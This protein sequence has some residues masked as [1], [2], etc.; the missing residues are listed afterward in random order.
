[1]CYK[2]LKIKE[3]CQCYRGFFVLYPILTFY[4]CFLHRGNNVIVDFNGFST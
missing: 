3:K 2:K 4:K 1:M